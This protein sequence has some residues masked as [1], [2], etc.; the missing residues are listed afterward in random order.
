MHDDPSEIYP[1]VTIIDLLREDSRRARHVR[2][3]SGATHCLQV[4]RH[5]RLETGAISPPG[6]DIFLAEFY[7]HPLLMLYRNNEYHHKQLEL[8][9]APHHNQVSLC[10]HSGKWHFRQFPVGISAVR[11]LAWAIPP[12]AS[13][14]QSTPCYRIEGLMMK[15]SI[16]LFCLTLAA[17]IVSAA[18][19]ANNVDARCNQLS[20]DIAARSALFVKVTGAVPEL[21]EDNSSAQPVVLHN[22]EVVLHDIANEIW[23]LRTRMAY[24]DCTRAKAFAY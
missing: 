11:H 12:T 20:S 14:K 7:R 8:D 3:G 21:G 16:A 1:K 10:F 5:C 9:G 19:A 2:S 18:P 15:K 17:G 24:L 23:S 13:M 6:I 4:S 22:K